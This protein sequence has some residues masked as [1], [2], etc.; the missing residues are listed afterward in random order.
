MDLDYETHLGGIFSSNMF[1]IQYM[2]QITTQHTLYQQ[3]N[4]QEQHKQALIN[5]GNQKEYSCR[6]SHV[7]CTRAK[8]LFKNEWKRSST[9]THT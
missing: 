2:V 4:Q 1:A 6:Q 9:R 8:V 5:K 3:G 7:Y